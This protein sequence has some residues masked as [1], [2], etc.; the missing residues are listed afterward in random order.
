MSFDK[1]RLAPHLLESVNSMGFTEPTP[2]QEKVIPLLVQGLDVIGQ[3]K[4]G[5]GKTAAFGLALLHLLHHN[6]PHKRGVTALVLTPTRELAVQV[7]D[8]INTLAGKSSDRALPIYGGKDIEPQIRELRRGDKRIV[9]GT[10]GRI[11]DHLER[12]TISFDTVEVL[13]I[14]EA[15]RMLDMGF[16]DDLNR[17]ISHLPKGKQVALFSA[18]MPPEIV[19][20][21][22]RMMQH[23]EIIKASGDEVNVSAI[24]QTYSSIDGRDKLSALTNLISSLKPKKTIIFTRTK[25]GAE[26]LEGFLHQLGMDAVPM[27]GNL[28][29]NARDR[30]LSIFTTGVKPFLVATD[31]AARGLDIE[32]VDLIVNYDLPIDD[33]T[34]LHR[35]GRTGRAGAQGRAHTFATNLEEIRFVKTYSQRIGAEIAEIPADVT[36]AK[37]VR[38]PK[39][40]QDSERHHGGGRPGGRGG[41]FGGRGRDGG[42]GGGSRFDRGGGRGRGGG[43]SGGHQGGGRS[44]G[45]SS[46]G[47]SV[48]PVYVGRA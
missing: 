15:D 6:F 22:K 45:G 24:T 27:H 38:P 32:G 13:I 39:H 26:K 18:T 34:Y 42:R 12:R 7:S 36:H 46:Q 19:D 40:N 44:H 17:I 8:E 21:A 1:L 4:T 33:K 28:S 9:V 11:L 47:R 14:D 3:A 20:L 31:L 35:I 30:A 43:S 10:P 2:I 41:G 25:Y 23:P 5:T 29:Q 16:I 37:F 48:R